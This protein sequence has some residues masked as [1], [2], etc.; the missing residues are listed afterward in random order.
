MLS[1]VQGAPHQRKRETEARVG[2]G[3]APGP[4]PSVGVGRR[5]RHPSL[6]AGADLVSPEAQ[7]GAGHGSLCSRLHLFDEFVIT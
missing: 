1:S 2:R 6:L 5:G 3:P 7:G 4:A